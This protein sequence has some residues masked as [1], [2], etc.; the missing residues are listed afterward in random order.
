MVL[1][2]LISQLPNTRQGLAMHAI[3]FAEGVGDPEFR[4]RVRW[5]VPL[6][7]HYIDQNETK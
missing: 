3:F 5:N 7:V 2:P 4:L 6:A 1:V